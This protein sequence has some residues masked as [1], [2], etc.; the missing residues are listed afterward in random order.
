MFCKAQSQSLIRE[1]SHAATAVLAMAIGFVLT[2]I[3][4]QPGQAQT[5]T[6]H[7][8]YDSTGGACC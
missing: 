4:L 1:N 7:M 5:Q 8:R 2:L 3:L 6:Y